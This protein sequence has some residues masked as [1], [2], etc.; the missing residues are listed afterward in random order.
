[1]K[2]KLSIIGLG[3]VGL[4]LAMAFEKHYSVVGYDVLKER[5]SQLKIGKDKNN[6]FSKNEILSSK[7]LKLTDNISDTKNSEIFIITVPT[8]IFKNNLPNL[9]YLKKAC[10]QVGKNIN[11]N[12]IIIFES[13]VYPGCTED[14]CVPIIEKISKKKI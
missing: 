6:E 11:K 3:Y 8:P 5:I 9:N 1:M 2:K 4:P 7:N 14:F 13:T 12:S 10:E